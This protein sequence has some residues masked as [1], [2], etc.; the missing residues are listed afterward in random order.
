[1]CRCAE[2]RD[3]ARAAVRAAAGG[4][5]ASSRNYLSLMA[6]SAL[7]D[8]RS[9]LRASNGNGTDRRGNQNRY[10]HSQR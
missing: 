6:Q 7:E 10:S 3:Q 8:M 2:R 1:M 4:D 5:L 9:A